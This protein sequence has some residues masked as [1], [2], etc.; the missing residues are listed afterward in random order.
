MRITLY[1]IFTIL[2]LNSCAITK[3]SYL[4]T[5]AIDLNSAEFEFPQ[6]DFKI[7]G[8]GAYHG[9]S[10]TEDVELTILSSLL[11]KK[12][13]KY[14][15]PETDY[16]LAHYFNKY[17][18][19]GDTILLRDLVTQYGHRVPQERTIEAYEK[20]KTIKK[21]NDNQKSTDRIKVIGIDR[22]AGYKYLCKHLIELVQESNYTK[23][24]ISS[25]IALAQQDTTDYSLSESS[26]VSKTLQKFIENYES[27]P[28]N[29]KL[30]PSNRYEVEHL[31][32]NLKYSYELY[33]ND[34]DKTMFDNYISLRDKY[35][36][37]EYK[38]FVRMGFSHICKSREG[39]S[40]YPYFFTRLIEQSIYQR[41]E[42]LTVMGYLTDSEVV[43]DEVF[44]ESGEYTGHTKEAG[45][46]IGD[47]DLEYFRGIQLLKDN[48]QSD[49]TLFRLDGKNTPYNEPESDLIEIIMKEEESN[50]DLVKGISTL[51][52]IDYAILIS[53][54]KASTPIYEMK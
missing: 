48:K 12:A 15:L 37:K 36:F 27:N 47:Y 28:E 23:A 38:Q 21:L 24:S 46:G 26:F 8:F 39:A 45:Y 40:S 16:S 50:G 42:I 20:W 6:T 11:R 14:Y 35:N 51:E 32:N 13:L 30:N 7:L 31:I 54:S 3:T 34:I 18:A 25:L 52:F 10:K 49:K 1:I 53:D 2:F 44:N 4:H 41:K 9:S 33:E 22:L 17:L 43:W 19:N 5:N 29:Y